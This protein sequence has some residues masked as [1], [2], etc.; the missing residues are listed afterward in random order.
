MRSDDRP[1]ARMATTLSSHQSITSAR[2]I[3][4]GTEPVMGAVCL[5][6]WPTSATTKRRESRADGAQVKGYILLTETSSNDQLGKVF[7]RPA[8]QD[9]Q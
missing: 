9:F 3:A 4:A 1:Y 6:P 8:K 7:H 5:Q 2:G